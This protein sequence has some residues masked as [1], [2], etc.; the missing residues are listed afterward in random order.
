MG[1]LLSPALSKSKSGLS[2]D[3]Q[4]LGRPAAHHRRADRV[5]D[6]GAQRPRRGAVLAA[7]AARGG[8]PRPGLPH[9]LAHL[10]RQQ[11]A[12]LDSGEGCKAEAAEQ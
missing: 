11:G 1:S 9:V 5:Q 12:L 7:A 4:D 3:L 10:Q 6:V 8:V 2:P